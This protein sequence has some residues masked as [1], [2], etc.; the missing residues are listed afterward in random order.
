MLGGD[1]FYRDS[2]MLGDNEFRQLLMYLDRPWAGYRKVR[3]G[4]KKRLRHHMQALGCKTI[5]AYLVELQ[6]L[7]D[8]RRVCEQHLLVTISRFFR[9]RQLWHDLKTRLLPG[10]LE[11]CAPPIR[12]WSAGCACGEEPYSLAMVLEDLDPPPTVE[13][14]ATDIQTVCLDRAR[15]GVYN[16]SSL[17][18]VPEQLRRTYFESLRGGRRFRIKCHRLPPVRWL[19]HH[20]LDPPPTGPFHMI[21]LR[22]NLLTYYQGPRLKSAFDRILG[23]L[24]PGGCLVVGSHEKPPRTRFRLERD[25]HCP[26]AYRREPDS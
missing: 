12:I 11:R 23:V 8:E 16:Q 10:L 20:L 25:E 3:K 22:Y 26:W 4:V 5:E 18:E 21:L 14:L 17:K 6:H 24:A 7:P 2:A 9:D 19:Q 15:Q 1:L 13:L